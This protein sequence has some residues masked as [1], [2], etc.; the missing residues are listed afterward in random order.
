MHTRLWMH[1]EVLFIRA[2]LVQDIPILQTKIH[3]HM[4]KTAFAANVE[5]MN[6]LL[7]IQMMSMKLTM[8]ENYTGL[9]DW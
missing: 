1:L 4:M 8:P 2:V 5:P 6:Q 7:K 3:M 9:P